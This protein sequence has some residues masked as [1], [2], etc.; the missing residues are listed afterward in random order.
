MP[1]GAAAP[2]GFV[3]PPAGPFAAQPLCSGLVL[4]TVR[5]YPRGVEDSFLARVTGLEAG[6]AAAAAE[7]SEREGWVVSEETTVPWYYRTR[8]VRLWRE[9][10]RKELLGQPAPRFVGRPLRRRPDRIPP[11]FWFLFQSGLDPMLIR[12]PEHAWLAASRMI[13]PEGSPRYIP[14]E[15]WALENLPSWALRKLLD[16]RG[17]AGT[18]PAARIESAAAHLAETG[19]GW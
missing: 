7:R 19:T 8:S 11:Q 3:F 6:H 2:D 16:S 4:G 5:A 12:L 13:A 14:A 15:T 18:A 9:R 1:G 10:P 17:Y